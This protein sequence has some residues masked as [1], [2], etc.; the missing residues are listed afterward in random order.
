MPIEQIAEIAAPFK[1]PPGFDLDPALFTLQCEA[2]SWIQSPRS[3]KFGYNADPLCGLIG[4]DMGLGKTATTLMALRRSIEQGKRFLFLVPGATI[5][6]W[7]RSYNAWVLDNDVDEFTPGLFYLRGGEALIPRSGSCVCSHAMMAKTDFVK[8]LIAANFDGVI[9]DEGH[10]F[11]NRDSKRTKHLEA[12]RNLS[13]GKLSTARIV[14]TGTPVRNYADE[15]YP[16]LHFISPAT[17]SF[18]MFAK[19]AGKYLT[20]D[21]KRL[22]NPAQFHADIAP[23][24]IRREAAKT[25][26]GRRRT[27]VYTEI[28]DPIIKQAYNKELDLLSNFS[29]NAASLDSM[30]L[31]GYLVRLRH[32]TGI[33]KAK[34]PSILEP[35][36]DYLTAPNQRNEKGPDGEPAEW[37]KAAI[38]LIHRLVA[39]RL[40]LSL[41]KRIPDLQVFRIQGGMTNSE[42]DQAITGFQLAKAPSVIL[43]NMEAGG[44]GIDGLQLCCS[45]SFTFERMWNGADELQFERRIDRTGQKFS[46]EQT[47]TM[48]TGTVDEFFDDLVES[49]RNIA[50]SVGD[51][52]WEKDDKF[53]QSLA[54]KVIAGGHLR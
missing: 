36:C 20:R 38:G 44:A 31:L 16:L 49:K 43:T 25:H 10:K 3:N 34:E 18:S 12:L 52:N 35:L 50:G 33:A 53:I 39:D 14:L 46:V 23:F 45:R 17:D 51:A 54:Q 24:Y 21:Q 41:T 26:L 37:N 6:Q 29:N 48:A 2:A 7:Q 19:F 32:I 5:I 47:Y 27:R 8:A 30:S 42:K 9:I 28:T 22:W 40:E 1:A 11:S 4:D 13:K 15:V